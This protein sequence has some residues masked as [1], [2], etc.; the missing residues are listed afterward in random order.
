MLRQAVKNN[1]GESVAYLRADAA[2]LPFADGSVDA[3]ICY[4][5]LY[6][7]NDPEA[8]VK[9]IARVVRP[10]GRI[11]LLTSFQGRLPST[12]I[13]T[14]VT[15]LASGMRFFGRDE[16]AGWLRAAGMVDVDTQIHGLAQTVTATVPTASPILQ[17]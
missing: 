1:S 7:I 13:W 15:G 9:E 17:D 16:L 10:G 8:V 4:A 3:A 11:S 5:A 6:L 14:S 12:R 2:N